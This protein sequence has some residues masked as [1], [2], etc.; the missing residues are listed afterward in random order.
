MSEYAIG[1][2]VAQWEQG[3]SIMRFN[4]LL[5]AVALISCGAYAFAASN[6]VLPELPDCDVIIGTLDESGENIDITGDYTG[7]EKNVDEVIV[8]EVIEGETIDITGDYPCMEM[9]VDDAQEYKDG[10]D[11]VFTLPAE[12]EPGYPG[13]ET[14]EVVVK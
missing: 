5:N 6:E 2:L 4:T 3:E 10:I 1:T 13:N 7:M 12:G 14:G 9:N 8:G 11:S